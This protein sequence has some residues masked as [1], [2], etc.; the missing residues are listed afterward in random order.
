MA[1][2]IISSGYE[3]V[4]STIKQPAYDNLML[5]LNDYVDKIEMILRDTEMKIHDTNENAVFKKP[6]WYPKITLSANTAKITIN[7]IFILISP[8]LLYL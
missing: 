1:L 5:E 6:F 7:R 4:S 8:L 2:G 3:D